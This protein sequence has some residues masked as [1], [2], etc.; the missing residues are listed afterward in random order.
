[1]QCLNVATLKMH[2]QKGEWST[3]ISFTSMLKKQVHA[4]RLQAAAS[5]VKVRLVPDMGATFPSSKG[6]S[7]RQER[8]SS[9]N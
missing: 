4:R 2:L 8:S 3:R 5:Q 7:E 1:M 9:V 6:K